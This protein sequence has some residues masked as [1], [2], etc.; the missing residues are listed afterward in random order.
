[1]RAAFALVDCNNFYASCEKLFRPDLRDTLVIVLSNNDGCV[2][3]RSEEAKALGIKMGVPVFRIQQEIHQHGIV[4]FSSNYAFYAELSS[5]VMG[6][7]EELAPRVEVYSIDEAFLDL[8]GV[9][10]TISLADFGR[11][12]RQVIGE[13]IGITVCV[14]AAPTKTLPKLANHAA[15]QYSATGGVVDLT[16]PDRQK[17][18]MSLLSADAV[19]G[20]GGRLSKQLQAMGIITALDL[21]PIAIQTRSVSGFQ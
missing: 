9:E 8:T 7:L 21:W 17:R 11:Q 2:V 10:S 18:L 19:W 6:V 13:W 3:A 16:N 1:M 12:I 15:K 5:R 14:G 4:T 20:I